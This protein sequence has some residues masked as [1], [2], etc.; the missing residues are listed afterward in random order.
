[1][2]RPTISQYQYGTLH[3]IDNHSVSVKYC[4]M[5]RQNTLGSLIDNGWVVKNSRNILF[6][7]KEGREQM[8]LYRI[9]KP[10][11]RQNEADLTER[12]S[13]MLHVALLRRIA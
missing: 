9:P 11:L 5:I 4:R 8:D 12:V 6:L 13:N 10:S 2:P 3:Y 7:T 1:M